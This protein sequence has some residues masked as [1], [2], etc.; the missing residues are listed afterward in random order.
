MR[1]AVID[2]EVEGAV[3][4]EQVSGL[5]QARLEEA[6]VVR[7]IVL[8]AQA[9][10]QLG[11]VTPPLE[12][13]PVAIRIGYGAERAPGLSPARVEG[14]VHVNEVEAALRETGQRQGVIAGDQ[15]IVVEH[16]RFARGMD[17]HRGL[18]R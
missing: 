8:V 15:E 16:D 2:V 11:P 10:Q 4:G 1:L 7:E 3:G 5:S 12:A 18:R 17:A 14:R 9:P 13:D 6:Q